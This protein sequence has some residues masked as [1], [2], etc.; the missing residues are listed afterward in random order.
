ARA[1]VA[2]D[3]RQ[4]GDEVPGHVVVIA[5]ADACGV[6]AHPHLAGPRGLQFEVLDGERRAD[7][8]QDRG[9][10]ARAQGSVVVV[11]SPPLAADSPMATLIRWSCS[12]SASG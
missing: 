7:L 5:V 8:V 9:P 3:D 11:T 2:D 1:L 4:A 6:D 10:H 12:P